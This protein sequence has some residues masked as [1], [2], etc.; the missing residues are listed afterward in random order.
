ME[1]AHSQVCKITKT[2]RILLVSAYC[3]FLHDTYMLVSH[4]TKITYH[5][6]WQ[7]NSS[8]RVPCTHPG[9]TPVPT[10]L[11]KTSVSWCQIFSSPVYFCFWPQKPAGSNE[12]PATIKTKQNNKHQK[13][14]RVQM[15]F[16]LLDFKSLDNILS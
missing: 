14:E 11:R 3:V 8:G 5:K 15:P 10:A 12:A 13:G 9:F 4:A 2:S 6:G 1:K 16:T 7:A